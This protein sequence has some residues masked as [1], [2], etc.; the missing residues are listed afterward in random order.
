MLAHTS[1]LTSVK[2]CT[3]S[4]VFYTGRAA[5]PTRALLPCPRVHIA[6]LPARPATLPGCRAALPARAS[7]SAALRV[8]P[9]CSPRVAPHCCPRVAPC[10]LRVAPCWPARRALLQPARHAPLLPSA[11]LPARAL[12]VPRA[13]PCLRYALCPATAPRALPCLHHA[14]APCPACSSA[15][16]C[17]CHAPCPA[18]APRTLLCL[19]HAPCPACATRPALPSRHAPCPACTTHQRP[20]LPPYTVRASAALH[21]AKS[22]LALPGC[23]QSCPARC[24]ALTCPACSRCLRDPALPRA[25][26]Q[27]QLPPAHAPTVATATAPTNAATTPTVPATATAVATYHLAPLLLTDTA[28]HGHHHCHT[29]AAAECSGV[30]LAAAASRVGYLHREWAV[31]WGAT[32]GSTC[33]STPAGSAASRRGGSGG[34]QQQKHPLETLSPQQLREWAVRWGSPGGGGF[35]GTRIGGVEATSGV[36]ATSLRACDSASAEAEP[37]EALHT[38]TLDSGA[39]HCFFCD[40]TTVTPLTVPVPVTM[41][42]P[43]GGPVVVRGAIDHWATVTQPGGELVAICTDSRTGEHL[44]TFTRRPESGL[45]TLTTESALVAEPGQVDASVEVAL[46]CSCRLL[47]HQTLLWHHRLGHPSLPRLRSM[48]SRLLVSGLPRSLPPLSRSLAP[49]CLPCVEG[50]QRAAPHS[51]SFPPTT[52]PLQNLHMDRKA[53]VCS[54]LIRW[55][56]A[57][58]LQLCAR[59]CEDLPV[60]RLHSDRG[61]E[62][63]SH[64]LE[65]FCGAEGIVRS[66]TLPASPQKNGIAER[67]IGLV[68][69]VARTSMIHKAAPHILWPFVVRY[70]AEQLN[71]L[72]RVSHPE[73]SPTLRWTGEGGDVSAFR[74]W[75]SLS[76]VRDL[77]VSKLSP[78]TL[79]CVFLGF[80]S[81]APPWQ[82]YHLG[83]CRMLSSHDVTFD[84]SFCFCRLHPHHSSPLALWPLSLVDDPPSSVAP[85]P[86][87]GPASSGVS[88]VDPPPLVEPLEVSSDTSGPA[89]G[90]DQTAADAV[91]PCSSARLAVPPGFPPRSSSPPLRPVAADSVAAGGGD[92]G[93]AES[94]GAGSGGAA[95]PTG[96]GGAASPTGAVGAGGLLLEVLRVMVLVVLVLVHVGKRLSRRSGFARGLS[97]GAFLVVALGGAS[98]GVPGVGYD[99]GTG[100][101]GT[102]ATGGPRGAAAVGAAAGSPGSRSGGAS[103]VVP[104]VG[105]T[106]GADTGGATGAGGTGSGGAVATGAG[107][108][109]GAT[110]QPQKSALC[111][112]LSLPPVATEFPVAG[113]SHCDLVRTANPTVTCL[114]STV[115][116]DPSFESADVSALVAELVDFDA[117]CRL[118]YAASLDRQFELEC[119]AAT[120][121]HLAS[122]LLC[123]QGDPDAL[124]IPTP[125]TYA[126]AIEMASWKSTGTYVD[127]V[128]QPR[129]NIVDAMWII[130]VKRPPGSPPA[131]KG[132]YVARGFTL[133]FAPST[134][135]PSLFLRTYTSLPPFY[136]IV[137]IDDLVFATADIEALALVKAEL[138]ER[139]T[140]TD[141]G[142]L[143]SYLGLQITRNR[144]RR[145]ITL[146]QS[147]M[148]QQVLQCFDFSWSSPQPTPLSK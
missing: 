76:L 101:G 119:L 43:S 33:E 35:R 38:F 128:P 109:G 37:E 59:L 125:R 7:H 113:T 1:H 41:A 34:G 115:V 51:S 145:T 79:R 47:T 71:R 48:H 93:G 87:P 40:S 142:E 118:D 3:S 9:R 91:A 126:E 133:G 58:Y 50:R 17:L 134:A 11:A 55:I 65:E 72:P 140:C 135:D 46:S 68:M 77:P 102:G 105:G 122:T 85:L 82:F 60:L 20:A 6:A 132:R 139:D 26:L 63:C 95:S 108:S 53:D 49:P 96:A 138:Q 106:G 129:A 73:T 121:P 94:G 110:T 84:K 74:V 57:V 64:L 27:L 107:G 141:L 13:L 70:A 143:R 104:R 90:G 22:C 56:H 32:T 92:S 67:R 100:A 12:P 28:Y 112:L 130:R 39:S 136:I 44:A 131:F 86:P 137:Y 78:H 36:V 144:A 123:P 52:T 10:S 31:R 147:H 120:A 98:A 2:V 75:G 30:S 69:E 103:A 116:T 81:N 16:P 61:G 148:V 23:R 4:A 124:D 29:S 111:H 146:T 83:S 97:V 62:F 42:D 117:L 99:R 89:E 18:S 54:V 88:Q 127:E 45:H 24:P 5:L 14:P 15:L 66:Y 8:A 114:L 21:A 19:R 80:P 25:Y